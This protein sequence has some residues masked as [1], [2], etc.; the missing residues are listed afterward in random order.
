ME[1]EGHTYKRI[2]KS[3]NSTTRTVPQQ[4]LHIALP[5]DFWGPVSTNVKPLNLQI[6]SICS[7]TQS[8]NCSSLTCMLCLYNYN[9]FISNFPFVLW[10]RITIWADFWADFYFPWNITERQWWETLMEK[11]TFSS[12][13]IFP[14][15]TWLECAAVYSMSL[16][17]LKKICS[18]FWPGIHTLLEKTW[19]FHVICWKTS[20]LG[21]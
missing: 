1:T 8:I 9:I 11:A 6:S 5:D 16:P 20:K 18:S 17:F 15:L 14:R 21:V 10:C 3:N 4:Q 12:F 7:Q 13:Q 2:N 19:L